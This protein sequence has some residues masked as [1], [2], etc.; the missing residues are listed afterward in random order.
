MAVV[1]RRGILIF[2][3][4][5]TSAAL[6]Y[7]QESTNLGNRGGPVTISWESLADSYRIEVRRDTQ[8]FIDTIQSGSELKLNLAPGFYEYRIHVLNP[9]G[10]DVSS[11]AWLPL[12]VES[13]RIPYF[14]VK[15]PLVVWEGDS[16]IILRIEA[17]RLRDGTV[18]L[19][20]NGE[21]S[22]ST[23]WQSDGSLYTVS[24]NETN[25]ES[26]SWNLEATDPS[27]MS[28]VHPDALIVRPT[29]SPELENLDIEETPAGGLTSIEIKGEAFDSEMS[30]R[31]KGPSGELPVLSVEITD[32]RKAQIYL[33]LNKAQPGSYN[34]ILTN[35]S[36]DNI[37]VENAFT[38][39]APVIEEIIKE[40]PR[41]EFQIGYAPTMIFTPEGDDLP[42]FLG[43]DFAL[44]FQSGWEKPF[45]RGLGVEIRAFG[46][47]SGPSDP[48]N[49]AVHGIGSLDVSGYYRPLVKGKAAPVFLL[50][51]GNMWSGFAK[52]FGVKNILFIR[53]GI[54]M[55]IVKQRKLTRIGL[56]YSFGL[57]GETLPIVSLMFR[58]GMR[59]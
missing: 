51:V 4:L 48:D 45:F 46:G 8:V 55:D 49:F 44:V 54:G 32:G 38:V 18:F 26:G 27:G 31:F 15:T 13:S 57:V 9:F 39:T 7:S 20:S 35:P 11:S 37:L 23:E 43:F 14:R 3:I 42:V 21:R 34:L 16:G 50:G 28:F 22:I 59:Y 10:K 41:F 12:N 52:E 19:L 36:G 1:I 30:V 2:F 6:S 5:L 40:Q 56:S 29:R 25:L 33:D 24:I 53:T 17:S 58:R 47:M